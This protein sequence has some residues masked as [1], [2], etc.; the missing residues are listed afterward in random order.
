M[1]G[2]ASINKGLETFEIHFQY[3]PLPLPCPSWPL[4]ELVSDAPQPLTIASVC[5]E[6]CERRRCFARITLRQSQ[7]TQILRGRA[8]PVHQHS[9]AQIW[10]AAGT[11]AGDGTTNIC[12]AAVKI[13]F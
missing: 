12:F 3:F 5:T 10:A 9:E 7:A 11:K 8:Q 2:S 1:E 13:S 6:I 4:V